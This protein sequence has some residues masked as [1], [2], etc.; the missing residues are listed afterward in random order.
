MISICLTSVAGRF[1]VQRPLAL[2]PLHNAAVA[3]SVKVYAD[4]GG[5]RKLN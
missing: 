2:R 5:I 4:K 1:A 3:F